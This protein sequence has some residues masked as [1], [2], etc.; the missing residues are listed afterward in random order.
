[1]GAKK[2]QWTR[3]KRKGR[4]GLG[5]KLLILKEL[6]NMKKLKFLTAIILFVFVTSY[7]YGQDT[8]E[9][10]SQSDIEQVTE[11]L[12]RS[13]GS[14]NAARIERGVKHLAALWFEDDGTGAEFQEFC[15][16][17]FIPSGPEL[18]KALDIAE[19]QFEAIN[20]YRRELSLALDYPLVT[21]A[22]PVTELDRL[23]SRSGITIDFYKSKL[24]QAIALNFP[25]YTNAEKEALGAGWSRKEWAMV[26]L[27]DMFDFRTDPDKEPDPVELPDALRDYTNLYIISMDHVLSP[28]LEILF[29]EG[30]RLNSHN[31]LRDE[32]KGL[33]S[34][35]NPLERQRTI[36]TI[37]MHIIHQT[38]PGCMIGETSYYWEPQANKVYV[39]K[40]NRF[41][42][43]EFEP[44][45]DKRYRVLHHN[46]TSKM[47]Q[48]VMYPEG[49]TYMSRTFENA[50][51]SEEKI[52]SLLESVVGA[53]EKKGVASLIEKRIGRKLE[54]F[55]IWYTG[56]SDNK[57]YNMDDLDQLLREK[58]PTPMAFQQDI[59][60]ILRRVGF[61]NF[62]ADFIGNRIV[63]D[64]IPSGGHANGPQ[65][66]GAKAH[67]RTRFEK[68]GL[69][70]KGYR[71][72]MHEIGH[73]I[74][75]NVGTYM[76]DYYLMKG[77]PC[78]PFTEA[79]ADLIAYRSLVGLGVNPE[80]SAREKMD[81]AL[82]AFWFVCEI[83]SVALH[84]IRVWNWL[85]D[86]PDA[87]V[88]ELKK[89]T[90]DI[91]KDIWNQYFADVFGV[92]DVPVL[93]I[94][95]HFISGALYLHSYPLGNIVLMQL[96]EYFEG[97]D[98]ATEMIR[99]C[100]IGKL[101][102]DLWMMEAT[103]EEFSSE[104][105]LNAMRKALEADK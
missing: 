52:V 29:P 17:Q 40:E 47:R 68:D 97:R 100:K 104:P 84:E 88:E 56:F 3:R 20:G 41:V 98:F 23:F 5:T 53:P 54:P 58:Y 77:I 2:A 46:M 101:T 66:K 91:A 55:D 95:N 4:K 75:Q 37:V 60:N 38:I 94:Y 50:Q 82:A 65:M 80:Y 93:A 16:K 8:K 7:G 45:P 76:T 87:T 6:R 72:G 99:T 74:Q 83:G 102:P 70:Y 81:N 90:I 42:E 14:E 92:K 12:T 44:E 15:I 79:M 86:H 43:T 21:M 48:D 34:R 61:Q 27:G 67:L 64:P 13:H 59:P 85:Y 73:T 9:I 26:R 36:S 105:L 25:Y 49:S 31:G 39:K 11:K 10:I 103:G 63:V 69:N 28:G 1:M 71:V 78:S 32:I 62:E 24:A 51:L 30:T 18:D 89:A 22:R 35:N 96:E 33:Y 57:D 19:Q